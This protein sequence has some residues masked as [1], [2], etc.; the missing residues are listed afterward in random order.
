MKHSFGIAVIFLLLATPVVA[1][2]RDCFEGSGTVAIK[3]CTKI[4]NEKAASINKVTLA[5]T[6]GARGHSWLQEKEY[7]KSISD[8]NDAIK[9]NPLPHYYDNRG[10]AWFKQR[11][12]DLAIADH[13]QA[14][15]RNPKYA[16]AYHNRGNT[17]RHKG[18]LDKAIDDLSKAL[19][20]QPDSFS[21]L[22]RGDTWLQKNQLDNAIAD[23]KKALSLN[24]RN[25]FAKKQLAQA[26]KKQSEAGKDRNVAALK[27]VISDDK[28]EKPVAA[29]DPARRRV[30]L[31]IGNNNYKNVTRLE[32]A[33]NDAGTVARAIRPLG[34]TVHEHTDADRNTMQNA[35]QKFSRSIQP[36]DEVLFY[37]AGHGIST[38]GRNWLLPTD[39]PELSPDQEMVITKD[40]F[41]ENE[42]IALMQDR[43]AKISMLI[44][45]ACRNNPFPKQGTRSLGRTVGLSQQPD[46]ARNTFVMYSAGIGQE[47]LDRL[48]NNDPNPNSVFTR[49][50]IPLLSEPGL[51][52]IDMAKKLQVEVE[53][54]ALNEANGHRQ[55]PAFYDQVR[56]HYYLVPEAR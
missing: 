9:L 31:V 8:F 48:S 4:I 43:G 3:A 15:R 54:T 53:T 24:P 46:L 35:L 49:K 25:N 22:I 5:Q 7:D 29:I 1:A 11:K 21:F 38:R 32:K 50:L 28:H 45:D 42:I 26:E 23:Y 34:F 30:A 19:E 20:L 52:L 13:S 37:F 40:A 17:W 39:I 55:F 56:G 6:Y 44:I 41:S 33:V 12:Y 2:D 18:N 47:A 36:G 16:N 51:S 14:I 27:P 10:V